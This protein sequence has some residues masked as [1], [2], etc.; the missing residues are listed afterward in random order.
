MPKKV[1]PGVADFAWLE[2]QLK[3]LGFRQISRI[4]FRNDFAR[5]GLKAPRPRLGREAGFMFYA[6]GL[7]VRVWTTWLRSEGRA[8]EVDAGWVL[9]CRGDAALYFAHPLHRTKDFLLNLFR[10]AWVAQWR[11]MHRPLCAECRQFMD[12]VAGRG[13]KSRYWRCDQVR[14]HATGKPTRLGWDAGLPPK[15]KRYVRALRKRR[16][17]YRQRR[18]AEGKP[19]GVALMT[20]RQWR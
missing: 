14:F 18:E 16:A 7:T 20:R 8:R 2:E 13:M 4:E 1:L 15:A 19:T 17:A 11:V 6:S 12:I 3:N 9:I 5:L 10:H